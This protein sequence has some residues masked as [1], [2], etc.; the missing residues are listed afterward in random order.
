MPQIWESSEDDK[1]VVG[2]ASDSSE[3]QTIMVAGCAMPVTPVPTQ[4]HR[5][6]QSFSRSGTVE[7]PPAEAITIDIPGVGLLFSHSLQPI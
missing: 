7:E 5:R 3:D 6:C 2:S 4:R 1:T